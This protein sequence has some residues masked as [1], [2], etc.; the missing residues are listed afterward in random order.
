MKI[1]VKSKTIKF[2]KERKYLLPF[3]EQIS[4]Q[5]HKSFKKID[6]LDFNKI[7]TPEL[8]KAFVKKW[9]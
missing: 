6:K 7:K 5:I 8:P 2:L 3:D 1:N 4:N 9:I